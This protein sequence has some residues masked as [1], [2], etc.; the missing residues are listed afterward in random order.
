MAT[1]G[2]GLSIGGCECC[3]VPGTLFSIN[4]GIGDSYDLTPYQ[5]AG[6][7]S[8]TNP[9]ATSW[10]IVNL[11]PCD[12]RVIASGTVT[13]GTL[14]ALPD[15]FTNEGCSGMIDLQ[16]GCPDWDGDCTPLSCTPTV[17]ASATTNTGGL[18]TWDLTP[19]QNVDTG[20]RCT[21]KWRVI[22]VGSCATYYSGNMNTVDG[23][24]QGLPASFTTTYSYDGFMELQIGC[25]DCMTS[26]YVWPGACP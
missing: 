3:C 26:T 8:V 24:F 7:V 18:V 5:D 20:N 11:D 19:Y 6:Y 15:S 9:G 23:S 13:N 2:L 4:L 14:D 10:R 16:I 1:P 25:W 17:Y 21:S 12:C 22:E